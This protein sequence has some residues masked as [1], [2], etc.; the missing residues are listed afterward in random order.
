[1]TTI[2]VKKTDLINELESSVSYFVCTDW[3]IY[4]RMDGTIDTRHNT[5][6]NTDWDKLI[7][8]YNM[9]DY[10]D[11]N[12]NYPGSDDYDCEGVAKWLVEETDITFQKIEYWNETKETLEEVD[13]V[14]I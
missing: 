11:G 3:A 7:D 4:V 9:G 13:I 6:I 12:E 10:N 8:L 2:K 1:M 5:F 14:L